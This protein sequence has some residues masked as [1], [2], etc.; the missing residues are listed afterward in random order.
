ME[1]QQNITEEYLQ[2]RFLEQ[3]VYAQSYFSGL[4][5]VSFQQKNTI[6][7]EFLTL[8]L[9]S[10]DL[11]YQGLEDRVSPS[12]FSQLGQLKLKKKMV[13]TDDLLQKLSLAS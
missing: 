10:D 4:P 12:L 2:Q 7:W 5:S 8:T 3:I 1:A 9:L 13:N 6:P 11:D